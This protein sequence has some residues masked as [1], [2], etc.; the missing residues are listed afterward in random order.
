MPITNPSQ[1]AAQ[2]LQDVV[3]RLADPA[4]GFNVQLPL[5]IANTP[6]YQ[7]NAAFLA[8][9]PLQFPAGFIGASSNVLLAPLDVNTWLSTSPVP[10][11]N[12]LLMQVY[13][14]SAVN[15]QETKGLLFD[16]IVNVAIDCHLGWPNSA[17]IYDMDAPLSAVEDTIFAIFNTNHPPYQYWSKGT[18]WNGRISLPLRS[19]L[20]SGGPGFMQMT[21]MT[22][23]IGLYL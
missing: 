2:A 8:N 7:A 18:I 5:T 19:Q 6:R 1:I 9:F 4:I 22:L 14:I 11:F 21:S 23:Q 3:T 15:K 16:G 12:A 17:V 10:V 13:V 20:I